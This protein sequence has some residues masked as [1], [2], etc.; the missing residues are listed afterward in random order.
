VIKKVLAWALL[1]AG[2]GVIAGFV[3]RLLWPQPVRSIT[4]ADG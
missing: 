1:L 3:A 4:S 2:L